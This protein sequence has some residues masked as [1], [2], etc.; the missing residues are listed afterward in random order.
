MS[1]HLEVLTPGP[2]STVQDLG[3]TG[4]QHLGFARSGAADSYAAE[5][6]NRL[7]DNDI[8]AAVIEVTLG[9]A[10]FRLHGRTAFT[11]TG[12]DA[13]PRLDDEPLEL[14]QTY[15]APA[16]SVVRFNQTTRGVRTYL[17]VQGGIDTPMVYGSRSTD[18]LAAIGGH[19]GR[20]LRA[21]DYL[22]T[23]LASSATVR[24]RLGR[25]MRP[26]SPRII[27]V[28][29][30]PGPQE[31]AFTWQ[32]RETFFSSLY[33]VT[34]RADRTGLFL[35]GPRLAHVGRA[36]I[37]SEG[38][39]TGAVQVPSSGQPLILLAE[40]RGIGGYTKMATVCGADLPRLGQ[41]RPGDFVLFV[42]TDH[43]AAQNAYIALRRMCSQMLTVT[44]PDSDPLGASL[45]LE[46]WLYGL[47]QEIAATIH[48]ERAP[49]ILSDVDALVRIVA[50]QEE[51]GTGGQ[52]VRV[53]G[54]VLA[55]NG[56]FTDVPISATTGGTLLASDGC[57]R[58]LPIG[59]IVAA[60]WSPGAW[61]LLVVGHPMAHCCLRSPI[62][63]HVKEGDGLADGTFVTS[64]S[65]H[66]VAYPG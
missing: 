24:R 6:G 36:D 31:T 40:Q 59:A 47:E 28:R 1:G 8:H 19:D 7:L 23:S 11:I 14:W 21:G 3:R 35:A 13:A 55:P 22:P 5:V 26:L 12:A 32:S 29:A 54:H 20:A 45:T 25:A 48:D 58:D 43:V 49:F 37:Y 61:T 66:P 17:C 27:L 64:V 51:H 57:L 38:V 53:R 62:G 42:P 10:A 34:S 65:A 50:H 9:G 46:E 4:F 44:E 2:L 18:V 16:H 41:A 52:R 30:V 63:A 56:V 15:V 60:I 39:V 33:R